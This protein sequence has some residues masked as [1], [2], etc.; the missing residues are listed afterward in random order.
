MPGR[1]PFTIY[2]D[3]AKQEELVKKEET[4]FTPA[5]SLFYTLKVAPEE[6]L[7]EGLEERIRKH[8]VAAKAFFTPYQALV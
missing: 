1:T 2:F 3:F 7:S 8:R 4:P 6:V 5:I